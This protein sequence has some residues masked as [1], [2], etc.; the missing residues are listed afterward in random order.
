[1]RGREGTRG[2]VRG[3]RGRGQDK[4][5]GIIGGGGIIG[6]RKGS[7]G[8]TEGR[9]REAGEGKKGN[10]FGTLVLAVWRGMWQEGAVAVRCG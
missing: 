10:K 6:I 9:R 1:M 2:E 5:E 4:R 3:T 8:E 7:R